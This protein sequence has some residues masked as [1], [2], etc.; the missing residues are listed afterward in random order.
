MRDCISFTFEDVMVFAGMFLA[1]LRHADRV[2]IAC[3]ALIVNDLGLVLADDRGAYPNGTYAVF[4]LLSDCARGTVYTC[5]G[6]GDTL[7]TEKLGEQPVLDTLAVRNA[8][9]ALRFFA[10]NRSEHEVHWQVNAAGMAAQDAKASAAQLCE[11]LDTRNSLET[12][13]AISLKEAP[14]PVWNSGTLSGVV[15]P[16]SVTMWTLA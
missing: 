11:A 3:Q 10:I 16:Y 13:N 15:A 1:L 12:P 7:A 5:A 14:A 9:G 4:K 8:D 6:S 2:K